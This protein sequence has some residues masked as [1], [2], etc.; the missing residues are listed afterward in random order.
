LCLGFD[1]KILHLACFAFRLF[2]TFGA[3]GVDWG[4]MVEILANP[5]ILLKIPILHPIN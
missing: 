1:S 5:Q 3:G 4:G 2:R